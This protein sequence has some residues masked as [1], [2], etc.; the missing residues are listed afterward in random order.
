M[1]ALIRSSLLKLSL[2]TNTAAAVFYYWYPFRQIS[3]CRSRL[4]LITKE[5]TLI[6]WGDLGKKCKISA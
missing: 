5:I 4:G 2:I 6:E 1:S 3:S